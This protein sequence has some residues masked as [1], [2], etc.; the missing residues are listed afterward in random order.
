MSTV[1][2]IA[3]TDVVA[4]TRSVLNA[5]FQN[6]NTD[7]VES[8]TLAADYTTTSVIVGTYSTTSTLVGSYD[9]SSTVSGTY[10][11]SSTLTGSYLLEAG[12][13]RAYKTANEDNATSVLVGDSDLQF[14][15]AANEAW[16]FEGVYHLSGNASE[17]FKTGFST[18]DATAVGAFLVE[19]RLGTVSDGEGVGSI[20]TMTASLNVATGEGAVYGVSGYV[21]SSVAGSVA[22]LWAKSNQSIASVLTMQQGSHL[23]AY[24]LA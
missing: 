8:S 18:P 20:A 9:T 5:N 1:S 23:I 12:I 11:T 19:G 15:I 16:G 3:A 2:S 24:K 13:K 14:P 10:A 6:L 7:K 21:I 4:N 22:T 17:D